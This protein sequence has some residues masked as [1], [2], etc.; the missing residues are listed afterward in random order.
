M[1]E[2]Q[3]FGAE[4]LVRLGFAWAVGHEIGSFV[5]IGDRSGGL[6]VACHYLG[7]GRDFGGCAVKPDQR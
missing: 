6:R 3:N 5:L 7:E 1:Q 4:D 2:S